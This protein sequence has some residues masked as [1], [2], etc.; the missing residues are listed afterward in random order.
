MGDAVL[1]FV[2]HSG[3]TVGPRLVTRINIFQIVVFGHGIGRRCYLRNA[4]GENLFQERNI[5]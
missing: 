2:V 4:F 3:C 5:A 1:V